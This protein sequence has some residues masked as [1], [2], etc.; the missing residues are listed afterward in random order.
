VSHLVR[1]LHRVVELPEGVHPVGESQH[2]HGERERGEIDP[3]AE[4]DLAPAT[5]I[6][7][8]VPGTVSSGSG[9]P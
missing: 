7:I 1:P 5:A 6:T 4:N 8:P 3:E 9:A 2:A